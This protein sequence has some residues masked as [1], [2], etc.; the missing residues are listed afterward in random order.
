GGAHRMPAEA[1][2][3][4][5]VA[6]QTALAPLRTLDAATLLARRQDKFLAMGRDPVP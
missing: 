4:V 1:I 3:G 2:A 6:I 5:G